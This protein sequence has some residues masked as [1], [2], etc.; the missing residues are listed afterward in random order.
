MF[1]LDTNVCVQYLR[2]K[3]ALVRQRLATCATHEVV[4]C[5]VVLSELYVGV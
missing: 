2:G 4:L 1:L 3:N 5:S